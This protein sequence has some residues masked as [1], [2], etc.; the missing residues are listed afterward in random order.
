MEVPLRSVSDVEL[1]A[2]I[3]FLTA[4]NETATDIHRELT[5][6]YGEGCMSIQMVRRW[7]VL[8]LEGR[9]NVHDELRS[10]RPTTVTANN[11]VVAIRNVVEEDRRVTI[12]EILVRLPPG[13][14]IRRSSIGKILTDDLHYRKVCARWV[15]RLLTDIHKQQRMNSARIFL[16]MHGREGGQLISRIVTGDETWVHHATPE[17]KRQSMVWKTACE[18]APKKAKVAHSA[19][20][21]M[22]TVF[23]DCKGI[24]L[25]DYLP[26]G[27]TVNAERY[28]DVLTKLRATIKRKRPG[29]LTR[30]V[31]L[32]HDNARPHSAKKT[33]DL[34][35]QF[36]WEIFSHPLYS[37]DL[38]PSDFHLFPHLKVHLG[39]LRFHNDFEVETEV[40]R[41]F[42]KQGTQ[43]YTQG[44]EK[45]VP[46]YQKC[47]DKEDDY[48]EK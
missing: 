16:E 4:K 47:L 1:R 24:L 35:G 41:W 42:K 40:N 46:R 22:A 45:L 12:D 15:P 32:M 29:L 34:L 6:V 9:E 18:S 27:T 37:P 39:G 48:V 10:G 19:G 28:C 30:K 26:R 14:E 2:V 21:V 33:Q 31:L 43:W 23:W 17:T 44:I 38:A 13:I 5:F 36:N 11:A 20:K 3:H 25:V 8:F 7:R